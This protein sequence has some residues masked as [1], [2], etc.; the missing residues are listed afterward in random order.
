MRMSRDA[1]E[2]EGA[3]CPLAL[4]TLLAALDSVQRRGVEWRVVVLKAIRY[5][6]RRWLGAPRDTDDHSVTG[7]SRLLGRL[8]AVRLSRLV[9][10]YVLV[11]TFCAVLFWC[12]PFMHLGQL[13]HSD[14]PSRQV[15][16][17]DC[18]YFSIITISSLGYGDI[19]PVG[20]ARGLACVEVVL[21]LT[22]IGILIARVAS[23]RS[24]AI[25]KSVFRAVVL[26]RYTHLHA[27][28]VDLEERAVKA[29]RT[30]PHQDTSGAKREGTAKDF[31]LLV[32]EARA[33]LDSWSF[34]PDLWPKEVP[35]L[36]PGHEMFAMSAQNC[37]L[38]LYLAHL[39]KDDEQ[40]QLD[41]RVAKAIDVMLN[42][43]RALP[44][45]ELTEFFERELDLMSR[46]ELRPLFNATMVEEMGRQ[47]GAWGDQLLH[48]ELWGDAFGRYL[49]CNQLAGCLGV[50][51]AEVH[52]ALKSSVAGQAAGMSRK[53]SET[54][55]PM[56]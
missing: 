46:K 7:E 56:E 49:H 39:R 30:G 47:A 17:P 27:A 22:I 37:I 51:Q 54:S 16:F 1:S 43:L 33:V 31:A 44:R 34:W 11:V 42:F 20:S 45:Y 4:A 12:L 15:S 32:H 9:I 24:D 23:A 28:M 52:D 25:A 13:Q 2:H 53:N 36:I 5:A 21:G 14:D 41:S 18:L 26:P 8:L 19:Q 48:D 3:R 38:H 50:T 29:A 40:G 35:E 10:S 55:K 6:Q